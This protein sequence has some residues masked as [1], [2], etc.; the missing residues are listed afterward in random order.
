MPGMSIVKELRPEPTFPTS[1]EVCPAH[2][3][4]FRIK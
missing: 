3:I 1:Q 4:I 2:F